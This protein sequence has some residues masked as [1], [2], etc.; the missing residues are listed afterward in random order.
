MNRKRHFLSGTLAGALLV[1][2][3]S[4]EPV[5]AQAG[6][7]AI[8][9]MN[10]LISIALITIAV[11]TAF[12]C[13][14]SGLSELR[15]IA[16]REVGVESLIQ[17]IFLSFAISLILAVSNFVFEEQW[18]IGFGLALGMNIGTFIGLLLGAYKY[19]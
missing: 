11:L 1:I 19:R 6:S 15:R 5:L 14:I 12:Y 10:N 8:N 3:L 13:L 4:T 18:N 9:G 17:P 7:T 16:F 2:V